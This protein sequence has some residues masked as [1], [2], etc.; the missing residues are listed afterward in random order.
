M[1]DSMC[2]ALA[3]AGVIVNETQQPPVSPLPPPSSHCQWQP[4][5]TDAFARFL[6]PISSAVCC[7]GGRVLGMTMCDAGQRGGQCS[8]A[9]LMAFSKLVSAAAADCDDDDVSLWRLLFLCRV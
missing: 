4:C 1:S 2:A 3:A 7:D 9:L 5:L 6:L 8:P